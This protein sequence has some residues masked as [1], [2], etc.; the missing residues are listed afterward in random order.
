MIRS[1]AAF[2]EIRQDDYGTQDI[3]ATHLPTRQ[4]DDWWNYCGLKELFG[5][6]R[7]KPAGSS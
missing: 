5:A 2:L 4:V 3:V 1:F 7:R 6:E